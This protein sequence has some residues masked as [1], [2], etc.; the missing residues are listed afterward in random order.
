MCNSLIHRYR[1]LPGNVTI[2]TIFFFGQSLLQ[3]LVWLTLIGLFIFFLPYFVSLYLFL[4]FF[5]VFFIVC[6]SCGE[7]FCSLFSNYK[8]HESKIIIKKEIQESICM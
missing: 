4:F 7:L 5:N 3:L 2:Q 6:I 1:S 8:L